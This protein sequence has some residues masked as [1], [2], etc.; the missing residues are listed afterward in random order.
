MFGKMFLTG[1]TLKVKKQQDISAETSDNKENHADNKQHRYLPRKSKTLSPFISK[2]KYLLYNPKYAHAIHWSADGK[3]IIVTNTNVFK[4]SILDEEATFKTKHFA[5]FVRQLN[6][7][8]FRKLQTAK[9]DGGNCN[10]MCFE[11]TYFRRDRPDLMSL[12]HR[13]CL[14]NKKRPEQDGSSTDE[15]SEA[16][17]EI[18]EDA[19]ASIADGTCKLTCSTSGNCSL[20]LDS[21]FDS[22]SA[23]EEDL[24]IISYDEHDYAL[25]N[26]NDDESSP[27]GWV[28]PSFDE[29][30]AYDFLNQ[31]FLEEKDAIQ[32]LLMLR[33]G[34]TNT[35]QNCDALQTLA[36]VSSRLCEAALFDARSK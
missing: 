34:D 5:S 19:S 36:E 3:S 22:S 30:S 14:V 21:S 26:T 32:T 27:P 7:Y 1:N 28:A 9:L 18:N 6:L 25:P 16:I 17:R 20:H 10:N 29:K 15:G 24:R 23:E 12:V 13:T 31:T 35:K 11:H 33:S 2:L 4:T 8:G